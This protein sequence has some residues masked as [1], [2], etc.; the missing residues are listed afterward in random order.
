MGN[1]R[2]SAIHLPDHHAEDTSDPEDDDAV[3]SA[4]WK[5]DNVELLTVGVDIGSSTSH[6]VF[7]RLHLQRLSQS[8]SSRFAVVHREIVHRSPILLTPY[9]QD[10]LIEV[11]ALQ[12]FVSD[13]YRAAGLE[14]REI[15]TGAVILT[16]VALERPN[17][18]AVAELFAGGGGK[19][20]CASAGHNLEAM[21]AAH[22]SGA[23]AASRTR[24]ETLLHID[25][26]GGTSKLALVED[27][28]VLETAALNVGGR[29]I[30]LDADERVTRIEPTARLVAARLGISLRVGEPL[31]AAD[32]DRL[33]RSLVDGL[34]EVASGRS[35]SDLGR[36]LLL[37]R[38]LTLGAA[39]PASVVSYS[40]GVSE[41][42]YGRE[43]ATFGD[44]SPRLAAGVLEA[45]RL[46]RLP[47]EP[48]SLP[49]GIRATVLGASQFTVQ[50]SGNTVHISNPAILPL[51]NLPV[52]RPRLPSTEIDDQ[53]VE[54][55]IR[56]AFRRLDLRDGKQAAAIALSWQGDPDYRALR[57]LAAGIASALRGSIA[58][59]LPL[60]IVLEQDIGRSLGGILADELQITADLISIDGLNLMEL[61]FVDI[62]EP[63][64]P[65][66]V[67][68][69]VIKS[70]AFAPG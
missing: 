33:S 43:A 4:L 47:A 19:F 38:P 1:G 52:V 59:R 51:R 20:V 11:D 23:V 60:V 65:A 18:R 62:G 63:L 45:H 61:D 3:G 40:G 36:T 66:N 28:E 67:V 21:L 57:A 7:A 42:I 10:G 41:Y 29:V 9:R 53:L 2:L 27:G 32:Q 8:L 50:L 15:D 12:S 64:Q 37:T 26:G 14:P 35:Q 48:L 16:G 70:L 5:L 54:A 49:E 68:P 69:V 24:G 44:L 39:D 30:A 25:V 55:A 31:R 56:E 34:V 58:A 13:G 46:G 22:G 6:L 17:A